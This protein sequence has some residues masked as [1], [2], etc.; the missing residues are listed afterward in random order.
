MNRLRSLLPFNSWKKITCYLKRI[1]VLLLHMPFCY[2]TVRK[3]NQMEINRVYYIKW[4]HKNHNNKLKFS[5]TTNHLFSL[6]YSWNSWRVNLLSN[7]NA[8]RISRHHYHIH[9]Q[10]N[11]RIIDNSSSFQHFHSIYISNFVGNV[12]LNSRN[13]RIGPK[14]RAAIWNEN[15]PRLFE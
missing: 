11:E 12:P 7:N 9:Q 15:L 8:I 14:E 1:V 13:S 5:T 6:D 4:C 3:L 10:I 2:L